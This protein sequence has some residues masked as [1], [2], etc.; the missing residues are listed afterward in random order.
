M[1]RN[2]LRQAFSQFATGVTIIT[3]KA[4]NKIYGI[5]VNSFTSLSLEPP[6]LL[7]CLA[8]SDGDGVNSAHHFFKGAGKF[9]VSILSSAQGELARQASQHNQ[10]ELDPK[11]LCEKGFIKGALAG[12]ACETKERIPVGDHLIIIGAVLGVEIFDASLTPLLF[13]KKLY[14]S[15]E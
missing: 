2:F 6:L 14:R 12:F 7:W 11:L 3:V 8:N 1:D 13:Y 4:E 15:L 5:T 10:H 9:S